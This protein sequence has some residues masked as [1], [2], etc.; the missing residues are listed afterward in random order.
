NTRSDE[1]FW[2]NRSAIMA[3]AMARADGS[4]LTAVLSNLF[5]L[6][7]RLSIYAKALLLGAI[8]EVQPVSAER[9]TSLRDELLNAVIVS[10]NGAH[11][12]EETNDWYNWNSNTR[13]TAMTLR[14]LLQADP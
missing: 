7:D 5:D 10:A 1:D 14:V 3:Y 13:T 6:R 8:L 9:V 4:N 2:L 11:W 12:E